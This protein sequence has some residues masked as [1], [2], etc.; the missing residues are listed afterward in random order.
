ML[1]EDTVNG[2]KKMV[3]KDESTVAAEAELSRK[4]REKGVRLDL[5]ATVKIT[6]TTKGKTVDLEILDNSAQKKS[7]LPNFCNFFAVNIPVA[8]KYYLKKK[9][10]G[11]VK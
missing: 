11:T 5:D 1:T 7:G 4:M 2:R 8:L 9:W 6:S 10:D 3:F